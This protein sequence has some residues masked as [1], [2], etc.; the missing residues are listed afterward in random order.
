MSRERSERAMRAA[1]SRRLAAAG[2]LVL[3]MF[4]CSYGDR[5]DKEED[6]K[7]R[8]A[9]PVLPSSL[10]VRAATVGVDRG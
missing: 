8:R 6:D 1:R 5:E 7:N 3:S 9:E 10:F 4:S 2:L